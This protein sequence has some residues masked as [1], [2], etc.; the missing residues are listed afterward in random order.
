MLKQIELQKSLEACHKCK[1]R[2]KSN[3]ENLY[4]YS[5]KND[6]IVVHTIQ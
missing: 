5:K 3:S 1:R 4:I 2:K 6:E